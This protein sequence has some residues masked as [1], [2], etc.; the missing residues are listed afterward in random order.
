MS[1]FTE[2]NLETIANET[3]NNRPA[4]NDATGTKSKFAESD[5]MDSTIE[6]EF[7][8][9]DETDIDAEDDT[10]DSDVE[11]AQ[12]PSLEPDSAVTE[13]QKRK[14]HE[15]SEAKRKAEWDALQ[16][17]KLELKTI[18]QKVIQD[19]PDN[20]AMSA[21]VNRIGADTERL[22]RRNMK[23]CVT[24]YIQTMCLD[25]PAFAR[26]VLCP[27]KTMI[28]CFKYITRHA[29]EY[30]KQDMEDNGEPIQGY[31]MGSDVPD[32]LCYQWAVDYFNDADAEED[33]EKDDEFVPK[34]YY[35]PT[36]SP[37]TKKAPAKK[38][39]PKIPE[40]K[41]PVQEE[42]ASTQLSLLESG[43]LGNPADPQAK[44]S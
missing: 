8:E 7:T 35:G 9:D 38:T 1:A 42:A 31:G 24:E 15:E 30:I 6:A 41:K 29:L 13:D 44:A 40:K 22:T 39:S 36:A 37:K 33:K 11:S 23:D 20:E 14:E 26:K 32:D 12:E 2:I 5:T 19:M 3:A 27:A 25:N 28:R 43:F 34:K 10:T 17:A 4:Y 18:T 16:K 21:S